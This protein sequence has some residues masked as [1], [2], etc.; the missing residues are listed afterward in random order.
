MHP[1]Y[2]L[3]TLEEYMAD[4]EMAQ[5]LEKH[6]AAQFFTYNDIWDHHFQFA[7]GLQQFELQGWKTTCNPMFRF[8][9][10]V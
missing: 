5:K 8:Q 2:L 7:L 1:K 6:L 10:Q 4:L 3:Q 9:V